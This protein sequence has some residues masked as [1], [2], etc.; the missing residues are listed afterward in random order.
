MSSNN[1]DRFQTQLIVTMERKI[2]RFIYF[3]HVRVERK[4]ILGLK[5][6]R[7]FFMKCSNNEYTFIIVLSK[8]FVSL[9]ISSGA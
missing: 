9:S 6:L 1:D 2:E 3:F 4:K 8:K 5:R 7:G